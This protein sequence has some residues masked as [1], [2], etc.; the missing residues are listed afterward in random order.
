MAMTSGGQSLATV[1]PVDQGNAIAKYEEEMKRRSGEEVKLS[2]T[3]TEML[4]DWNLVRQSPLFR[5]GMA[6]A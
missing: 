4:H 6:K 2:A 1:T 3:N 5:S